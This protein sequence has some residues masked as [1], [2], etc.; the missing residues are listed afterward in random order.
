LNS[1]RQDTPEWRFREEEAEELAALSISVLVYIIS[2]KNMIFRPAEHSPDLAG[3]RY[4]F[5]V[6]VRDAFWRSCFGA[7]YGSLIS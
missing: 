2:M 7:A 1:K 3:E 5:P 6:T 4:Q